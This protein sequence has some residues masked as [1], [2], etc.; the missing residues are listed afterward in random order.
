MRFKQVL[1]NFL[2]NAYKFTPEWWTVDIAMVKKWGNVNISVKDSGIWISKTD[3][4]KLFH[5][6]SQINNHLQRKH[7]GTGLWLAICKLLTK[8]MWWGIWV[9]SAEWKWSEFYFYLPLMNK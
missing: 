9:N 8:K 2:S 4:K 1:R 5:K 6:F 7:E 3:Q